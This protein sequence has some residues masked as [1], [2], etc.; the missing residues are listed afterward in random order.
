MGSSGTPGAWGLLR[1]GE[2]QL[3]DTEQ[4]VRPGAQMG[5]VGCT[6]MSFCHHHTSLGLGHDKSQGG[7]AQSRGRLAKVTPLEAGAQG[8]SMQGYKGGWARGSRTGTHLCLACCIS[9]RGTEGLAGLPF[10]APVLA[11]S[12]RAWSACQGQTSPGT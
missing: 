4:A 5:V 2:G 3:A 12:G 6:G 11:G 1:A 7:L 10:P 9:V 8:P